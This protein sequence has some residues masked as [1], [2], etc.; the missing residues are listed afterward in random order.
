MS[1]LHPWQNLQFGLLAADM[2]P[3]T[4]AVAKAKEEPQAQ[5]RKVAKV[6]GKGKGKGRGKS[7]KSREEP[8]DCVGCQRTSTSVLRRSCPSRSSKA[9]GASEA[10]DA[11][12]APG[13]READLNAFAESRRPSALEWLHMFVKQTS[14]EVVVAAERRG[15]W[16]SC[17]QVAAQLGSPEHL[18]RLES[19]PAKNE[20]L[21]R[22]KELEYWFRAGCLLEAHAEKEQQSASAH[23]GQ[24]PLPASDATVHM[25]RLGRGVRR[26]NNMSALALRMRALA[27]RPLTLVERLSNIESKIWRLIVDQERCLG[28]GEQ[29][30]HDSGLTQWLLD[31]AIELHDQKKCLAV[32]LKEAEGCVPSPHGAAAP[33]SPAA[34][35]PKSDSA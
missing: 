32:A 30:L 16:L 31:K 19:R 5:V 22:H 21:K 7:A 26:P 35:T 2:A 23:A 9:T 27:R 1:Q 8:S 29:E 4:S 34:V 10:M 24:I 25:Q 20:V 12:C 14:H 11:R 18:D 13:R 3:K 6:H 17:W 28:R 33:V 15:P